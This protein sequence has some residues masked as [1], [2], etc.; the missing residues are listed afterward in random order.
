MVAYSFKRQF[1]DAILTGRKPHTMR[2][3][4]KR[5][6]RP[7][8]EVQLYCGMRSR[9]CFL[10]ARATCSNVQPVRI[11]FDAPRVQIGGLKPIE[12]RKAL[13][14][15][16]RSDGFSDWAHLYYFWQA[17]HPNGGAWSGVIVFWQ[18]LRADRVAA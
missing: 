7:G 11:D 8:E 2:N 15:F 4:R 3:E 17:E 10:V 12:G 13:D 5:H 14:A 16:A 9:G 1:V 18:G 6:A